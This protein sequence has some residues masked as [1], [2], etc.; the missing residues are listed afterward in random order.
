MPRL[1][2]GLPGNQVAGS[3]SNAPGLL[4]GADSQR[5]AACCSIEQQPARSFKQDGVS[6]SA[7]HIVIERAGVAHRLIL[8]LRR[9]VADRSDPR[10]CREVRGKFFAGEDPLDLSR[11]QRQFRSPRRSRSVMS[12]ESRLCLL[13]SAPATR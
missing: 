5:S 8:L 11:E 9:D 3:T 1:R 6:S 2:S 7:D 12:R 4:D 10:G 13:E